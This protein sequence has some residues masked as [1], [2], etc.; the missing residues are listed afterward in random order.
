MLPIEKCL[1][2]P[3][4]P[5]FWGL[6]QDIGDLAHASVLLLQGGSLAELPRVTAALEDEPLARIPVLAH[7]DLIRGLRS[8]EQGLEYL[9]GF[10]RISGVVTTHP[11]LVQPARRLG[12]LSIVRVFLQDSRALDR[13]LAMAAKFRPDAIE[14]LP[15]VAAAEVAD[16]LQSLTIPRIAGGLVRTPEGAQR[17][18]QSG[19]RAITSTLPALWQMNRRAIQGVADR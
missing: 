1:T 9:G 11:H 13:G 15:A 14:F 8:D 4:I 7:I 3:V 16:V 17:I 19:C 12:L 2:S 18:L 6:P 10:E 5:V